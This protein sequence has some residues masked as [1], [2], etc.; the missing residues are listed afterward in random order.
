MKGSVAM[1]FLVLVLILF[2]VLSS[3]QGARAVRS[4][5]TKGGNTMV[6]KRNNWWTKRA[7]LPPADQVAPSLSSSSSGTRPINILQSSNV[8]DIT[9]LDFCERLGY[10][11]RILGA[12]GPQGGLKTVL[13]RPNLACICADAPDEN[14]A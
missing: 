3:H 14:M 5:G 10:F 11:G 12:A 7:L 1:S 8:P 9:A 2:A 6:A 4:P 13:L